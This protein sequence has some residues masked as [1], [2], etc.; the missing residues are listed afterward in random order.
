MPKI[1]RFICDRCGDFTDYSICC[2]HCGSK[3][4][5]LDT[6]DAQQRYAKIAAELEQCAVDMNTDKLIP[7]VTCLKQWA[8][9]LRQ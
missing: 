2:K 3:L 1:R 7:I 4:A 9:L 5:E 6:T 8:R